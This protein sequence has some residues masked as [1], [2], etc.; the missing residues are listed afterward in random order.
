MK[1]KKLYSLLIVS[2]ALALFFV[3]CA[4]KEEKTG[5][6]AQPAAKPAAVIDQA[7]AGTITGKVI[8]SG[9]APKHFVIKMDKEPWCQQQHKGPVYD[10]EVIVNDNGAL[11]NVFVY[12]KQGVD[13]YSFNPSSTPAKLDQQG[14]TYGP[15]VLGLMAGQ[16]LDIINSDQATHNIHPMP[17][18]NREW[19]QSQPAG[20]EVLKKDFPRAEIMI[21]VK[22]N[23]HPWMKAYVNVVKNPFFAVTGKDGTFELKGLPPGN[24]VIEA[25]HE[26]YG[27]VEQSVTLGPK[28]TKAVDFTIKATPGA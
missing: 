23:Q 15:H 28:E 20:G 13:N 4:K 16:E 7:T 1:D 12:V 9:T 26:K 17:K 22:C 21:P 8:F 27:A 14:C 5:E 3:A 2:L 25:V 24:Y 19:N 6:T 10:Q 11:E 18:V